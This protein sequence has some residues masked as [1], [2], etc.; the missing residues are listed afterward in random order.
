MSATN[1]FN[2]GINA[3]KTQ[4]TLSKVIIM[5]QIPRYDPSD[6]DP[7]SLKPSLSLLFNN[8]MTNLWMESPYKEQIFIGNHN[9]ECNGAIREARYRQTKSGKCDYIHLWGSSGSKTYTL[10]VLHIL[11]AAN[12]TSSEQ[13]FL[14]A[15]AQYKYQ[16]RNNMRQTT[17]SNGRNFTSR[18]QAR[19][20][21]PPVPTHNRFNGLR[22]MDQGN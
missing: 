14:Q 15:C 3:L 11:R 12:V 17:K 18:K 20:N 9:I 16:K 2:A 21:P 10:S 1:V 6:V 4:P 8:T 7:L 13:H 19:H 5:K 22:D